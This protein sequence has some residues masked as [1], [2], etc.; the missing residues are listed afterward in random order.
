MN[1]HFVEERL[2]ALAGDG[3]PGAERLACERHLESCEACRELVLLAGL[4]EPSS[5]DRAPDFVAAVLALTT[6]P[7]CERAQVLLAAPAQELRPAEREL[8]ADH[9]AQCAECRGLASALAT[10]AVDLPR[11]ASLRP[12]AG[13]VDDVLK[14]TL[15]VR[16][17]LRRWWTDTWPRWVRRPRF[18]SEAAYVGLLVLI[19][20]FSTPGSPLEAVPQRALEVAQTAPRPLL[21]KSVAVL[22]AR[23]ASTAEALRSSES[24]ETLAQWQ[25]ASAEAVERAWT[26]AGAVREDIATFC[27][28]VASLLGRTDDESASDPTDSTEETS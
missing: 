20:V 9:S 22:E 25:A 4:P 11:L 10:L 3:L 17:Q 18:A 19:L 8:L 5:E 24:A 2:E 6:G 14:A 27:S 28:G 13:F 15:P 12:D 26:V 7:A 16:V 23:L 21:G 1:C